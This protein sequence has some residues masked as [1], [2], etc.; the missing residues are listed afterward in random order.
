MPCQEEGRSVHALMPASH[1]KRSRTLFLLVYLTP[2]TMETADTSSQ[3]AVRFLSDWHQYGQ[4]DRDAINRLCRLASAPDT[5]L[6]AQAAAALFGQLIEPL[7][8]SFDPRSAQAY[9]LVMAQVIEFFRCEPT[10][11]EIDEALNSLGITSEA[12]LLARR[13]RTRESTPQ[14]DPGRLRKVVFLSRVTIGADVA[15]TSVLLGKMRAVAS[16]AEQVALGP[17]PKLREIFGGDPSLRLRNVNYHRGGSVAD[18]LKS[19]LDV[20]E[21]IRDETE[22][23]DEIEF[24]IIDPDSRLTQL[25]LL[26]PGSDKHYLHFESRTFGSKGAQNLGELA[27]IWFDS[28]FPNSKETARS[29]F[30]WI[31]PL[32]ERLQLGRS[33]VEKIKGG[34]GQL[35]TVVSFGVGGNDSKRVSSDFE[36]LFVEAIAEGSKLVIDEGSTIDEERVVD[37]IAA[38]LGERGLVVAKASEPGPL[39][40]DAGVDVLRWSGGLGALAGLIMSSDLYIGYDSAGQ[41]I[42]AALG[43][44]VLTVFV[45]NSTP[46]FAQRWRP[47]GPGRIEVLN[48]ERPKDDWPDIPAI[49]DEAVALER[50]LRYVVPA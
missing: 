48:L 16:Q 32:P 20:I 26:P 34:R 44:P 5:K 11:K 23:L 1:G 8:D 19:W 14:V 15:I 27:S 47:F 33:M 18:R 43:V 6:G 30:P 10:G 31:A 49:V 35:V 29:V 17:E 22:G 39:E 40:F 13:A 4:Y 2:S 46:R 50:K 24:A 28:T 36:K 3:L 38:N 45:N 42:A 7:N 12:S 37:E 25:G 21:I 41:H 9:D